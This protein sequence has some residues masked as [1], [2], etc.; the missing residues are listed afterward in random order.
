MKLADGLEMLPADTEIGATRPL[1]SLGVQA[2][3]IPLSWT[4]DVDDLGR[5]QV[6]VVSLSDSNA[7][8]GLVSH[9]DAPE[10]ETTIFG[11]QAGKALSTLLER[12]GTKKGQIVDRVDAAASG[13]SNG[14]RKG[15]AQRTTVRRLKAVETS[16]GSQGRAKAAR[17]AERKATAKSSGGRTAAS[18]RKSGAKGKTAASKVS[19]AS[20][21]T[22]EAAEA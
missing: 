16:K 15:S 2:D 3:G 21:R 17:T 12:L 6:A 22:K 8:F 7:V 10:P 18:A 20:T 4:D 9:P 14:A 11:K 13:A 1:A 5:C 19:R